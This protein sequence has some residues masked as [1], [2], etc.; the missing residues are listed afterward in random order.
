[1]ITRNNLSGHD[2]SFVDSHLHL[3][4]LVME[5]CE[6]VGRLARIGCLP[7][8]WAFARD[9]SSSSDLEKYLRTRPRFFKEI[10]KDFLPCF[11][12]AGVHPRN[13]PPDLEARHVRGLVSPC[14][15]DPLCLGIGEI[16]LETGSGREEEIFRAQLEMA[17][18]AAQRG[19][20]M[21]I[22][23]PRKQK[24]RVTTQILSILKDFAPWKDSMVVDH[25]TP[26][27]IGGVL[28]S[29]FWAGITVSPP[30]SSLEDVK[31]ILQD[32]SS[33]SGKIMLNTDSGDSLHEDLYRISVSVD[34][35]DPAKRSLTRDNVCRFFGIK[36]GA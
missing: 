35:T 1:M 16:G 26:E 6:S 15:D 13:I 25:C 24:A 17:E 28:S 5:A 21:G 34:L 36:L 10:R 19:K 7:V 30:K 23:T 20:V 2:I 4:L 12:L 11:Y 32:H 8:S 9:I 22:H 14:L 29:G 3:D 33:M 27:T 18:E 31:N